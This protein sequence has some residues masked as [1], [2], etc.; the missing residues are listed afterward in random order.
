M[1]PQIPLLKQGLSKY[2]MDRHNMLYL[3]TLPMCRT[4][5]SVISPM[6]LG[7]PQIR[8]HALCLLEILCL[9]VLH[10]ALHFWKLRML[11]TF[12]P[13]KFFKH[14]FFM[15]LLKFCCRIKVPFLRWT[16]TRRAN[17]FAVR[18]ASCTLEPILCFYWLERTD[19]QMD[20]YLTCAVQQ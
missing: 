1:R 3:I 18:Q 6:E 14:F 13:C 20:Y 11:T 5:P 2:F 8:S 4:K 16:L 7:T 15:R 19:A 12:P 17:M 9:P 10:V